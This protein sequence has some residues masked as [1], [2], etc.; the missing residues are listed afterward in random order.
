[1]RF[2]H[3]DMRDHIVS[4]KNDHGASYERYG[5]LQWQ[6]RL[7]ISFCEIFGVVQSSTFATLSPGKQTCQAAAGMSPTCQRR[8]RVGLAVSR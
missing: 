5:V 8:H 3:G 2:A 1:M 7:K 6:S 4:H